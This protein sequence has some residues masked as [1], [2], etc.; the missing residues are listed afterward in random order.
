MSLKPC[1]AL[2]WT[3][4]T[5][6]PA[7]RG[8]ES[9][10]SGCTRPAPPP[11]PSWG[12]AHPLSSSAPACSPPRRG[13]PAGC[14]ERPKATQRRGRGCCV[15]CWPPTQHLCPVPGTPA[16]LPVSRAGPAKQ[17]LISPPQEGG[18][19]NDMEEF[20]LAIILTPKPHRK[21]ATSATRL[22]PPLPSP[23]RML[24]FEEGSSLQ[25]TAQTRV[26]CKRPRENP[27]SPLSQL[28]ASGASRPES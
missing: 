28:R 23:R 2:P 14:M 13:A 6:H 5:G 15:C 22:Q 27:R 21:Q 1:P 7:L 24:V 4:G 25:G 12:R 26:T 10:S 8:S 18:D 20:P 11:S 17:K 16:A 19:Q 9:R 3:R